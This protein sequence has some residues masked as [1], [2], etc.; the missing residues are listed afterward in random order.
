MTKKAPSSCLTSYEELP[1]RHKLM[2]LFWVLGPAFARW[3][4]SHMHEKGLTPQRLRLLWPLIE[5]GP[6]MMSALRDE[7]GVTATNITALVDVLEKDGM[8][9]RT[10]HPTDRRAT[11]IAITPRAEKFL[12]EHCGEF[13][14]R[15]ADIFSGFSQAEQER[16]LGFLEKMRKSLID[17]NVLE[18][19]EFYPKDQNKTEKKTKTKTKKNPRT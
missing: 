17:R 4:E 2:K 12:T 6:M 11:M 9:T 3:A 8:V 7:L 19:G 16:F 10:P 13:R 15:V 5:D 18:E 1:L 14:D